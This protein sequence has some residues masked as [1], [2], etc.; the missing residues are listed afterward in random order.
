LIEVA[1]QEDALFAQQARRALVCDLE[2]LPAEAVP[3][4]VEALK[5]DSMS[6][7]ARFAL[8]RVGAEAV[9]DLAQALEDPDPRVR[10][11]VAVVL[12]SLGPAAREAMPTLRRALNDSD[13]N[14]RLE[15]EKSLKLVGAR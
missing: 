7:G 4:L 6:I 3:V 14:V 5:D 15:V 9:P 12:G 2:P 8:E 11:G 10:R 1:K 13:R